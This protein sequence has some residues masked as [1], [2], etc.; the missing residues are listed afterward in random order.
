LEQTLWFSGPT[1]NLLSFDHPD[2]YI[3]GDGK[4]LELFQAVLSSLEDQLGCLDVGD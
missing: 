1:F 3:A 2:I 4:L